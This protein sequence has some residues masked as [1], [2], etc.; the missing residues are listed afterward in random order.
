MSKSGYNGEA[1]T[2]KSERVAFRQELIRCRQALEAKDRLTII[3]NLLQ[4]K[5]KSKKR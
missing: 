2:P 4:F 1:S 5:H 3:E